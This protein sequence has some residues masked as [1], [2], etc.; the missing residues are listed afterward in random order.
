[1]A[2]TL[3]EWLLVLEALHCFEEAQAQEVEEALPAAGQTGSS[4]R[5]S[6]TGMVEWGRHRFW[7]KSDAPRRRLP[8]PAS[9]VTKSDNAGYTALEPIHWH[10]QPIHRLL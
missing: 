8:A 2:S 4:R 6:W 1:V 5:S 10:E 7:H 9:E 3:D